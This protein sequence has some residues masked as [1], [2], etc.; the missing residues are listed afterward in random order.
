MPAV[1][2][3]P[4][5][6][7]RPAV[8]EIPAGVVDIYPTLV[9]IMQASVPNQVRPLDGISL[10]P[11]IEGRMQQRPKPMGFWQYDESQPSI[12]TDSGPA[13]WNDNRYKLVKPVAN[14]WELYDVTTDL[15]EERTWPPSIRRSSTA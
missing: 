9:E 11:L 6:I 5:R 1:I 10:I 12:N 2:E 13:A 3:W 14:K 7:K 4:A 15:A 8:T